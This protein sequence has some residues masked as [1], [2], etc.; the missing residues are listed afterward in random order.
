VIPFAVASYL[1]T[2]G[3]SSQATTSEQIDYQL[4]RAKNLIQPQVSPGADWYQNP[5]YIE[6]TFAPPTADGA[7]P[8][9]A[10]DTGVLTDPLTVLPSKDVLVLRNFETTWETKN[11]I[12]SILA[13]QGD[14]WSPKFGSDKFAKVIS[15]VTPKSNNEVMLSPTA[16]SRFGVKLGDRITRYVPD[17]CM[18]CMV[19]THKYKVVGILKTAEFPNLDVVYAPELIAADGKIHGQ[20]EFYYFD[21]KPL[22]WKRTIELN[23]LGLGV[24]SRE[25]LANPPALI[26]QPLITIN[27]PGL[28]NEELSN[29]YGYGGFWRWAY[30]GLMILIPIAVIV[31]AAFSFGARRQTHAL[32]MLSSV[33]ATKRT[34]QAVT[35]VSALLLTM[36]GA[37]IGI[38]L[39]IALAALIL[40][41]TARGDWHLFA[42]LHVDW[43]WMIAF[44]IF[45][46]I[47]AFMV[48]F[49]PARQSTKMNVLSVLRGTNLPQRL[50]V[51][52]GVF[53]LIMLGGSSVIMVAVNAWQKL[54]FANQISVHQDVLQ[55]LTIASMFSQVTLML[56]FVIGSGWVI[57]G[58]SALL[59]AL[60]KLFKNFALRFAARDLL[61]SRRRFTPLVSAMGIVAFLAT[62]A[63]TSLHASAITSAAMSQS[64]T[65]SNQVFVDANQQVTHYSKSAGSMSYGIDGTLRSPGQ[66]EGLRREIVA[67]SSIIKK[68]AI[69]GKTV[70][71][72][73][74]SAQED[75]APIAMAHLAVKDYC[76]SNSFV[77]TE[78]S[79]GSW[80]GT[81]QKIRACEND[82]AEA[83]KFVIGDVQGLRLMSGGAVN[84]EAERVLAAGGFVAFDSIYAQHGTVNIDWVKRSEL[85]AVGSDG[86]YVTP[87]AITS[88]KLES[89]MNPSIHGH[90]FAFTGMMS[91]ETADKLGIVYS[92]SLIVLNTSQR[93]PS[94]LA[95]KWMQAGIAPTYDQSNSLTPEEILFWGNLI[96]L[97][98]VLLISG[99]AIGLTQLEARNDQRTLSRLGASRKFIGVTTAIQLLLL[100]MAA[101]GL[102]ALGG[103]LVSRTVFRGIGSYVGQSPW[104]FYLLLIVV[105][106]LTASLIAFLATPQNPERKAKVAIE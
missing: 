94:E 47:L 34:I 71:P 77:I 95:D 10:K 22:S 50:R 61:L 56:G 3:Q 106:P 18:Q 42:G 11:G 67:S 92:D 39:G 87:A 1:S 81:S 37:I 64:L 55:L 49:V 68:S 19:T 27:Q 86:K 2:A 62:A 51:R 88:F 76:S 103:E 24:L 63:I 73:S 79:S 30:S 72:W 17:N 36:I 57:R 53:S 35:M 38:S 58:V 75:K 78:G 99:L 8:V 7:N 28:T 69:L 54:A 9:Q 100:L 20:T 48:G 82:A 26:D 83:T 41:Q 15:G 102:G 32:A 52:T 59:L 45:A 84:P 90:S 25:V 29:G 33:G 21:G 43:M 16:M 89:V 14:I 74:A 97:G 40:P 85:Y 23:K 12:G 93:I 80:Q 105:A 104:E 31:S 70:D 13:V 98:L 44:A 66:V 6:L 5:T 60:S 46:V 4:G 96:L 65:L 91:P 101:S